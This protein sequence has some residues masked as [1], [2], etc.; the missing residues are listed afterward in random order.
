MANGEYN[1][2]FMKVEGRLS[3]IETKIDDL[4]EDI[5]NHVDASEK[6]FNATEKQFKYHDRRIRNNELKI[7]AGMTALTVFYAVIQ[8]LNMIGVLGG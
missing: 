5:I 1:N 3:R 2:L 7:Y 6:K 8:I 4:K